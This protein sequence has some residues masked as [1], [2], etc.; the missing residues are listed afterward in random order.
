MHKAA[1]VVL[2]AMGVCAFGQNDAAQSSPAQSKTSAS[3]QKVDHAT[4]YYYYTLAHMYAELAEASGNRDYVNKAI[5]DYKAA[6]K[7]DPLSPVL[8]QELSDLYLQTGRLREAESDAEDTLKRNPN[9]LNALRLLARIYTGQIGG[10]QNRIDE[11]MLQKAIDEYQKV[12]ALAPKD[13][14]SW[15]MLGRLQKVA[16]NSTEAEKAYKQAL[17]VDPDNEDALTGLALVYSDLGQTQ[18]AAE[19]LKKM[20]DKNPSQR[21]LQ[22]LAAAYEQMRQ[23]GPAADALQKALALN[24]PNATD[25]Q[26]ALGQDL[27][28]AGRYAE[29]LKT[30][31]ALVAQD[32]TDAQSYLRLS[33]IYIQQHDFEKAREASDKARTIAPDSLEI[34]FN[35]VSLLEAEGKIPQ[36]I[37]TLKDI[38]DSTSKKTYTRDEQMSRLAL[39]ERLALLYRNSDQTDKAVETFRQMAELD[40]T[41]GARFG[42]EIVETYRQGHEF[43][44][45]EQEANADLKKWPDD[46]L[47][48]IAHATLLADLGKNEPAASEIKKLLGGPNDRDTYITLA[49]IYDKGRKWDDMGKALDQADKLSQSKDEHKDIWFMRGAMYERMKDLP[50]AEEQFR[51]VLDADPANAAALNYLGYMLA[52]RNIRLQEALSLIQKALEH[53]PGNGAYLDSLGWVYYRL[54]RYPEAEQNLRLAVEK[55]PNDPTVHDHMA[56]VLMGQS[57][58]KEAVAQWQLSLKEWEEG[59]PADLEPAEVAR[60]KASLE[61]AKVRLAKES[62]P[63]QK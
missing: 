35:Q 56:N 52:D 38:L 37:Q 36:A 14:D 46:R 55:T 58:V 53:D 20:A 59:A 63:N 9:D 19:I 40:S 44:K 49:Q 8:S 28:F 51:K 22:A 25:V 16:Q 30:Y 45:A 1:L 6:I 26:R 3:D 42:A 41:Q 61:K 18:Q 47:L 10:P 24:P 48:H 2:A 11:A 43:S 4:S 17:S 5:D 15:L 7:A 32:P 34:R 23:Y 54:G 50:K 12:V 57:K 31:Q 13:L 29:A 62:A 21:S 27:V 33:Q 60:E 39:M